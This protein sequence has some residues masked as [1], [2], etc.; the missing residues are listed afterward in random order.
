M[1][2]DEYITT[3]TMLTTTAALIDQLDLA[4]LLESHAHCHAV[5]PILDPTAYRKTMGTL[6]DIE[7]LARAGLKF[8]Q[9]IREL[10]AAGQSYTD[11]ETAPPNKTEVL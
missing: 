11:G 8:Q 9:V 2:R 5:A 1:D 7:K 10:K 6:V 3:R 4:G